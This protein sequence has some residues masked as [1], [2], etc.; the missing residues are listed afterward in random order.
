MSHLPTKSSRKRPSGL[1]GKVDEL[2]HPESN[3]EKSKKL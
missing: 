3:E 2:S 1:E